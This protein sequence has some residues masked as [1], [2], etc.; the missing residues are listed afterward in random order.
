MQEVNSKTWDSILL[1]PQALGGSGA[2]YLAANNFLSKGQSALLRDRHWGPYKGFLENNG[3]E[4]ETWPL[5]P[6]NG[7][8]LHP[9]FA[10]EE[11][12]TMLEK[13]CSSQDKIMVW[14]NDPAHNP[15]IYEADDDS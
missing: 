13:L 15:S 5:L 14:L 7:S 9:Y 1:Q 12:D 6:P 10:K 8:E 3:L 4:F 11:F 2:L